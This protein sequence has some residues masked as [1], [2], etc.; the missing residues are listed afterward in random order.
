V[1]QGR[2]RLVLAQVERGGRQVGGRVEKHQIAAAW[3]KGRRKI[4]YNHG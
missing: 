3:G 4:E 1:V 2:T